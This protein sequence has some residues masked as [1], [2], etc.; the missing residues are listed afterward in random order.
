MRPEENIA[1]G[2]DNKLIDEIWKDAKHELSDSR[3]CFK[4][5]FQIVSYL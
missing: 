1:A 4:T 5:G 2:Y 3:A